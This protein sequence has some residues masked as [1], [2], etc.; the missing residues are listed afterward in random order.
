MGVN[1]R[2]C[3]NESILDMVINNQRS[4]DAI[5]F[6]PQEI[7]SSIFKFINQREGEV[8]TNR[9]G[10]KDNRRRTLEEIGK[11]F[12]VTR[13]RIR[14]LENSALKKISNATELEEMLNPIFLVINMTLELAG[15][16]MQ[17]SALVSQ[18]LEGRGKT[19]E[20]HA[21]VN[22]ILNKFF[23]DR[24]H[25]LDKDEDLHVSWKLPEVSIDEIKAVLNKLVSIIEKSDCPKEISAILEMLKSEKELI[26]WQEKMDEVLLESMLKLCKKLSS[27][28]FKEWGLKGWNSIML[29]R[30]SDKIYLV[31]KKEGKP[32]HFTEIAKRINDLGLNK[33]PANPAT[34]HNELILDKK[35]VLVGRGIYALTEWGY[36]P[37]VVTDVIMQ[38]MNEA[39]APL[40]KEDIIERVLSKRM[41]KRSTVALALMNKNNFKRIS[42]GEY[43]IA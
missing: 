34:I 8:L 10:L 2:I 32:M 25:Y 18:V 3:M 20:N 7:I 4:A 27:N 9:Y 35:F 21:A 31:L 24:F 22:F 28:P 11:K 36:K 1:K 41:V 19:P 16:I 40:S 30:M 17:E 23:K 37:G 26:S 39:K 38:I 14:Q 6:N 29:K 15:G 5:K 43:T 33:K 42:S 12:Q 13:E